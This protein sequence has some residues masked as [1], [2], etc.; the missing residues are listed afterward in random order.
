MKKI[1]L[2]ITLLTVFS[3][4]FAQNYTPLIDSTKMWSG[5]HT[6]YP[7]GIQITCYTKFV[8]DTT[9][10]QLSYYKVW[11]TTDTLLQNWELV[12]TIRE[13]VANKSVYYRDLDGNEGKI[14][15]FDI[16][17]GDTLVV[18]NYYYYS[19]T[20]NFIC[21]GVDSVFINNSHKNR[22]IL[23]PFW[24]KEKS[25]SYYE[26]WIEGIGSNFGVL[27]SSFSQVIGNTWGFLCYYE[28]EELIYDTPLNQCNITGDICPYFPEQTLDTAYVGEYYEYQLQVSPCP[29]D[30]VIFFP[31]DLPPGLELNENTGLIYGTPPWQAAGNTWVSIVLIN[32]KYTTEWKAFPITIIDPVGIGPDINN[33]QIEL[34]CHSSDGRV[35]FDY[36]IPHSQKSSF[37]LNIYNTLGGLVHS[38]RISNNQKTSSADIS[39]WPPGMYMAIVDSNGRAV[40]KVKFVVK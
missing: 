22:Y 9:I 18:E 36:E 35:Y 39:N 32:W 13:D 19:S 21:V 11:E 17:I 40:G 5:M 14:Y 29:S 33:P 28:N 16:G 3:L 20:C 7:Q 37:S 25:K 2:T 4:L 8:G 31:Y 6:S 15:D 1:L 12:G 23:D 26:T 34:F 38:A 27:A 10:N 30:S 24:M